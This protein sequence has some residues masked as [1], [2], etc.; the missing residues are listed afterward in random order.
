[1]AKYKIILLVMIFI[2]IGLP[3]NAQVTSGDGLDITTRIK[4]D[5]YEFN[6]EN[7]PPL[8]QIAG[9]PQAH[10]SYFWEFGDGE[11]SF[12]ENPI[13][14]YADTGT[15]KVNVALTNNYGNGGAPRIKSR[16]LKVNTVPS[17]RK[18]TN[19]AP[20]ALDKKEAV[21]IITN[22]QPRPGDQM[23]CVI[24]YQNTESAGENMSGRLYLFYNE[25]EFDYNNFEVE[26]ARQHH[27]E[28]F[29][30][31][32]PLRNFTTLTNQNEWMYA[33]LKNGLFVNET[34]VAPN[35]DESL[36]RDSRSKYSEVVSWDF[37]S[38]QRGETRNVFVT[39][40]TDPQ[41]IKDTANTISIRAVIVPDFPG[42]PKEYTHKMVVRTSHDPNELKVSDRNINKKTLK[43]EGIT[44]TIKFQNVGRGA[45]SNI[46]IKNSIHPLLDPSTIKLLDYYPKSNFC[47]ARDSISRLSCLDT[48]LSKNEIT[49][50][51]RNIYL[52]GTRQSDKENRR[53]TNGW[54]T[55]SIKPYKKFKRTSIR[56]K[57]SIVFDKNEPVQT[58]SVKTIVRRNLGYTLRFGTF[59]VTYGFGGLSGA[60]GISPFYSKKIYYQPEIGATHLKYE[61]TTTVQNGV[62]VGTDGNGD[63]LFGNVK[64]IQNYIVNYLDVMPIHMRYTIGRFINF[65]VGFQ[66]AFLMSANEQT[67]VQRSYTTQSFHVPPFPPKEQ[68]STEDALASFPDETELNFFADVQGGFVRNG[69]SVGVRTNYRPSNRPNDDR[70]NEFFIQ[71]YVGYRF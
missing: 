47:G 71:L 23:I 39:L 50:R 44:Y 68:E 31:G 19:S 43:R 4:N 55:Y 49:W 70:A 3:V 61:G 14:A 45:A 58:N 28:N 51:F 13:Y 62:L 35:V 6:A 20:S 67:I 11:Y 41:T 30:T 33:S 12:E 59:D 60:F 37:N 46:D 54:I 24:S 10:Y 25:K 36:I 69:P 34:F 65:G 21:K 18:K 7:K 9:A 57:A 29:Y 8:Q 27:G 17:D 15:V 26:E 2:C 52:P 1:M 53:A 63:P 42:S 66:V 22:H 16:R 32:L 56:S 38:M 40:K 5:S 64:T 48:V